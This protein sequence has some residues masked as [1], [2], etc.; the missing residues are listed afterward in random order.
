MQPYQIF[1]VY[2]NM[3]S[4]R[5][6]ISIIILAIVSLNS[7]DV[8]AQS[9]QDEEDYNA[10]FKLKNIRG[11]AGFTAGVLN[12]EGDNIT[13]KTGG[14]VAV[15]LNHRLA[16]GVTGSGFAGFQNTVIDNKKYS[17]VG[18]YGGLLIEPIIFPKRVVHL[19]FPIAFGGG[20][21]Q[22]FKD[23]LGYRDW[24]HNYR[25]EFVQDFIY[26]EPGINLEFN[27]TKFMRFGIT[28]SYMFTNT[29]NTSPMDVTQLDG[30]SIA[31]NLK[32]G[33]FK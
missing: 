5:N 14:S 8:K 25:D 31:A 30:F 17:M 29:I 10:L 27:L 28:S 7:I 20:E 26:I 3:R 13:A 15:I 22:Y 4:I 6:Y 21:N 11:Y 2:V 12:I 19:S 9:R 16:L 1:S 32:L 24:D 33:W 23:S 18:G